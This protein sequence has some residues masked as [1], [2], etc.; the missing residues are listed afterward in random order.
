MPAEEIWEGLV[1]LGF[2][3]ISVKQMSTT[4]RSQGSASTSLPLFL[5]TLP[6]SEKSHETF[7]Q[8]SLCYIAIKIEPCKSQTGLMQCHNCQQFSNVWAN[9]K[10]PPQLRVVWTWLPPQGMSAE[11]GKEDSTLACCNWKLAEGER[12]HHPSNYRG[13]SYAYTFFP[14]LCNV[15]CGMCREGLYLL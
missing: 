15:E 8:T 4:R 9:C 11:K 6:R 12:P 14:G 3:I 13:C 5:I 1:E 7:K 10:Q 2:D